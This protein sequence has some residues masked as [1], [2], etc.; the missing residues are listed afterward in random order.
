MLS[1]LNNTDL[2]SFLDEKYK[3]Y[4]N[5]KFIKSDPIQVPHSFSL[6][7][8]IE[9]SAFLTSTISWGNRKVIIKN[10]KKMMSLLDESP[11]DFILNHSEKDLKL[12]TNFVHR[13]FNSNDL[14]YFVKALNNIY[15]NH[16]GL[17]S[18]FTNNCKNKSTQNSIHILKK[19][20][21]KLPH[22]NRTT[23]HIADPYKGSSAK[24]I[25]MFLR[26]MV[27]KDSNGVDFGIWN[28]ISP[29]YLSC[30][31]DVHSGRVARK[32]G[33][34]NR[35]QND[36]KAVL[37]LDK[38]LRILDSNDPVKYDFSLFGLGVFEGF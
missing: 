25:N 29:S 15:L 16:G 2:K 13:T 32:L 24:R 33:I 37:E 4:N 28:K 5:Y 22:E 30:P 17:E 6:K 26:W 3:Q 21:F 35:T 12:F 1:K 18:V 34:L 20:F 7:E 36:H 31:L 9:I 27:R 11:Y 14:I 23:K 10:A 19:I 38:K 8:D